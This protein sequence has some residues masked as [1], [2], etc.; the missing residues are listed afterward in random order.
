MDATQRPLP[1]FPLPDHVVF[2]GV[3]TPYRLFEPR[4]R[5]LAIDLLERPAAER[6]LAIP[7]LAD[8]DLVERAG[9]RLAPQPRFEPVATIGRAAHLSGLPNGQFQMIFVGET[10][11]LLQEIESPHPYRLALTHRYDDLDAARVSSQTFEALVQSAAALTR[12][13]GESASQLAEV[14]KERDD[15]RQMVF[16]LGSVLLRSPRQRQRFLAARRHAVRVDMLLE[17][18]ALLIDL[19]RTKDDS[20][21]QMPEG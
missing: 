15:P 12:M 5:Q 9:D 11:A 14:L 21:G 4:Y 2:P 3:P 7:C 6:E 1:L 8:R 18:M 17:Q 13:L 10:R 20:R 16:T 19:V